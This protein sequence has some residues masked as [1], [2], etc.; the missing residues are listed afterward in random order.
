MEAEEEVVTPK[1]EVEEVAATALACDRKDGFGAG[2]TTTWPAGDE[3]IDEGSDEGSEDAAMDAGVL[4]VLGGT[5]SG[6]EGLAVRL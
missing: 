4:G 1:P 3:G 6:A 5:Y 2:T